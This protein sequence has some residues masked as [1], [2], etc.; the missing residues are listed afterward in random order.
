METII[1]AATILSMYLSSATNEN[2]MYCYNANID[3]G[4]VNTMYVYNRD[5]NY[6]TAKLAYNY[7]YDDQDRLVK[8]EVLRWNER[9][10]EWVK[11]HC[12]ELTYDIEGYEV[13]KRNWNRKDQAYELAASLGE[14]IDILVERGDYDIFEQGPDTIY[15]SVSKGDSF[16]GL[17]AG[18]KVVAK[19][20]D[21]A[22]GKRL[23]VTANVGDAEYIYV[24]DYR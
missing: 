3:N 16:T 14:S 21:I 22:E 23:T 2:A 7:E 8:K 4:R 12:L 18:S 17:P 13:S 6:L 15:D 20:S 24:K 19:V 10:N 1:T 5:G 11:D 9:R